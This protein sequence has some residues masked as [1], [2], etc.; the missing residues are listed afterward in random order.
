MVLNAPTKLIFLLSLIIA[1][2]ALIAAFNVLSFIPVAAVWIMT[3][4][5]LLLAAGVL[6]K[7]L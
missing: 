5:Y 3:I 4:A 2:V 1:V 6:F 7:G